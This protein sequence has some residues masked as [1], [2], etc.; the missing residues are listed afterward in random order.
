[1][2]GYLKKLSDFIAKVTAQPNQAGEGWRGARGKSEGKDN[3]KKKRY[4]QAS[5]HSEE[6]NKSD[7]KLSEGFGGRGKAKKKRKFGIRPERSTV[8]SPQKSQIHQET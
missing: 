3:L 4:F 2:S 5:P 1:L 8:A 6:E 7:P